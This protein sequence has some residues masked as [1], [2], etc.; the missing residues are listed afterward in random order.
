M[1]HETGNLECWD[2]RVDNGGG[3]LMRDFQCS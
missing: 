3:D 1:D 2:R